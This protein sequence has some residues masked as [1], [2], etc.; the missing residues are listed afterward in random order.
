MDA[1][2]WARL[3]K[4]HSITPIF[5]LRTSSRGDEIDLHLAEFQRSPRQFRQRHRLASSLRPLDRL[6]RHREP[7]NVAKTSE[8]N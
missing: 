2:A 5:F 7:L 3:R 4:R 8:R 6:A 1:E